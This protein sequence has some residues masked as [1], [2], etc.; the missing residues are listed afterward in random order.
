MGFLVQESQ[1]KKIWKINKK[2]RMKFF[3][4]PIEICVRKMK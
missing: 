2:E 3:P 1:N 4:E